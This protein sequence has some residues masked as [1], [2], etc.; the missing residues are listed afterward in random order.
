MRV[1]HLTNTEPRRASRV[2]DAEP[3]DVQPA[4][5]RAPNIAAAEAFAPDYFAANP[6]S[7][8]DPE[9]AAEAA[10]RVVEYKAQRY[11]EL[12]A[13]V[14]YLVPLVVQ[15]PRCRERGRGR[16][17]APRSRRSC[18]PTTARSGDDPPASTTRVARG[19]ARRSA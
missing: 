6:S 3:D 13:S 18:R 5:E 4:T 19:Y 16:S 12:D 17:R 8:P 1:E 2:D 14:S 15:V 7:K 9:M 10:R 11:A